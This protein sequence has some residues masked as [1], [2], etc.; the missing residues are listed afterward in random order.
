[1]RWLSCSYADLLAVPAG[2]L[3]VA[4]EMAKKQAAE[5]R[6]RSRNRKR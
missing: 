2:Y 4:V 1:M 3:E 5:A 6:A